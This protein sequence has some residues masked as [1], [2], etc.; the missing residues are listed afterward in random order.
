MAETHPYVFIFQCYV[1]MYVLFLLFFQGRIKRN[2]ETQGSFLQIFM[3]YREGFGRVRFYFLSDEGDLCVKRH[4]NGPPRHVDAY[5][6]EMHVRINHDA[7]FLVLLWEFQ[8]VVQ[9]SQL[10]AAR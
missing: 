1:Y 3:S 10:K 2:A 7:V 9:R 8:R 4:P 5:V 6:P